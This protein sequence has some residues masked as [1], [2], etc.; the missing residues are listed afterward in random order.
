MTLDRT[1]TSSIPSD[2]SAPAEARRLVGDLLRSWRREA[3]HRAV[4]VTSELVSNAVV[5]GRPGHLVVEVAIGDDDVTLAVTNPG[6]ASTVATEGGS[7][8][9]LPGGGTSGGLGLTIVADVS[10]DW[11]VD[12]GPPARVWS[13]IARSSVQPSSPT[14]GSA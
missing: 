5:H 10:E 7:E 2:P 13:R 6:P 9:D 11:G 4:L 3:R 12:A 14:S 1:I 8:F